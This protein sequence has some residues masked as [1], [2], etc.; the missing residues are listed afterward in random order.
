MWSKRK[1]LGPHKIHWSYCSLVLSHRSIF[2]HASISL[3]TCTCTCG[4]SFTYTTI[5]SSRQ[6]PIKISDV[7]FE[8][9]QH[10]LASIW[11]LY[12]LSGFNVTVLHSFIPANYA[13]SWWC[14]WME[15][16]PALLA[17]CAGNSPVTGEFPAQRPVTRSFDVFV[18][19]RMNKRLSKQSGGWWF[20]TPLRSLW[21]HC[22]D[23]GW[24]I[25][26]SSHRYRIWL[27][28]T[29]DGLINWRL[30]GCTSFLKDFPSHW[31]KITVKQLPGCNSVNNKVIKVLENK[32][33]R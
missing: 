2:N 26:H 14:H 5:K 30:V 8:G 15:T 18:D 29:W 7:S 32:N 33:T 17:L 4:C 19:L 20:E 1:L 11:I 25:F 31:F 21:R 10:C 9:S 16:F 23:S 12:T 28:Y 27:A 22:N 6:Q 3:C 13:I 24:S